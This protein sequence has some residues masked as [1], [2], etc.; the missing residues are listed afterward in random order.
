MNRNVGR[1]VQLHYTEH[2][3]IPSSCFGDTSYFV[4]RVT[5]ADAG[6]GASTGPGTAAGPGTGTPATAP[7]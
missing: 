3:G 4:D 1:R 5:L 2:R 6:G 7:P